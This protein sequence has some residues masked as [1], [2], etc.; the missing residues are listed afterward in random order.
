MPNSRRRPANAPQKGPGY[1]GHGGTVFLKCSHLIE[2]FLD[3]PPKI[4]A[5]HGEDGDGTERGM[6]G[7]DW[8]LQVPLGMIVRERV[9]SGERSDEGRRIFLSQFRYQFLR[10]QD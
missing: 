4:R 9:Y 7:K 2:S 8:C 5:E 6:H 3:V 10:H 1:G